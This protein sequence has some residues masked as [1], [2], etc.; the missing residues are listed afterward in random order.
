MRCVARFQVHF[1]HEDR[2]IELIQKKVDSLLMGTSAARTFYTQVRGY[3]VAS[4]GSLLTT[5]HLQQLNPLATIL[6]SF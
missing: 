5:T 4:S 1:L 3:I 2:I 6:F